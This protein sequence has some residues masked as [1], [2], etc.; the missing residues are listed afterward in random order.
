MLLLFYM[1]ALICKLPVPVYLLELCDIIVLSTLALP[2]WGYPVC[3]QTTKRLFKPSTDALRPL[4]VIIII[5]FAHP[6]EIQAC[7]P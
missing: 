1:H 6:L 4:V 2:N 7:L 3:I 5:M